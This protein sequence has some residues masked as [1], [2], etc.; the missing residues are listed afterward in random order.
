[1]ENPFRNCSLLVF[2][3]DGTLIDTIQDIERSV[4]DVRRAHGLEPL[5]LE[6]V[7]A[8]VG[9]GVR[10]LLERTLPDVADSD[11]DALVEELMERY[12]VHCVNNP[13]PYPGVREFLEAATPHHILAVLTNK[14]LEI[15]HLTLQAADLT[16][17]FREV[18]APENSGVR[19][20]NP[21]GLL[22]LLEEFQL[23]P[24]QVM[25]IGD[26]V[27]DFATG[28]AAEVYTVGIRGGYY[29]PGKPDPDLWVRSWRE[30]YELWTADTLW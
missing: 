21:G 28:H 15:T 22:R 27:N 1:M 3:L 18:R 19:K 9:G 16:R 14:P 4:N 12:R 30:L 6:Q 23:A 11:L 25:L 10:V 7:R 13:H 8:A 24:D 2:D 17:Y 26:S 29:T 20:P 5:F